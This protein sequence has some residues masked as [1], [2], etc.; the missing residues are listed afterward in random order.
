MAATITTPLMG[1]YIRRR[2]ENDVFSIVSVT[3]VRF[4]DAM[5]FLRICLIDM[6]T[7]TRWALLVNDRE[8]YAFR[9][10]AQLSSALTFFANYNQLK[11]ELD[12]NVA[13]HPAEY[14]SLK[15]VKNAL[16]REHFDFL[17]EDLK[18]HASST[19]STT[20]KNKS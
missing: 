13:S 20:T 11:I 18:H 7:V 15:A 17:D 9:D 4:L 8:G 1:F 10:V 19:L 16:L 14:R 2:N 5:S 3:A 12:T 6:N